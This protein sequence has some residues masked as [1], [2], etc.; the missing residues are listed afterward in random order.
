LRGEA[1]NLIVLEK[2]QAEK[3]SFSGGATYFVITPAE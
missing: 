1:L 3:I 2:G